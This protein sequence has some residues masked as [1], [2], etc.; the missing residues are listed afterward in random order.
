MPT[1]SAMVRCCASVRRMRRFGAVFAAALIVG[2][3]S[4]AEAS[5]QRCPPH[6]SRVIKANGEAAVYRGLDR[7]GLFAIFGC[8]IGRRSYRLGT[9]PSYS[10]SG[11]GGTEQEHLAGTVVAYEQALVNAAREPS[12][13]G[14]AVHLV[15]VR[16]LLTGR[17]LHKV[18]TGPSTDLSGSGPV[19]VMVLKRDGAVAWLT[20]GAAEREELHV[21]DKSG[22]RVVAYGPGI[23]V[24]SLRIRGST[25]SWVL[26][27]KRAS[28][29]IR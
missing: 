22:L 3:P 14:T 10:S 16:N 5:T 28:A 7:E 24:R 15:V 18:P 26:K 1:F 21:L 2:I 11:G 25:L 17:L 20:G 9:P 6:G 4:G 27:G 8:A 23:G 29:R 13:A 19:D 12:E